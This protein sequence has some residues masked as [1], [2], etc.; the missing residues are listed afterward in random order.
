MLLFQRCIIGFF[1]FQLIKFGCIMDW[2]F[3]SFNKICFTTCTFYHHEF[4]NM[5]ATTKISKTSTPLTIEYRTKCISVFIKLNSLLIA[6]YWPCF[7]V[8]RCLLFEISRNTRY[9]RSI[10]FLT[11]SRMSEIVYFSVDFV[12][13]RY[14]RNIHQNWTLIETNAYVQ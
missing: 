10:Q 8:H 6:V 9:S 13:C 2:L 12:K 14:W 5:P 1:I 4:W 11:E 7:R 3:C